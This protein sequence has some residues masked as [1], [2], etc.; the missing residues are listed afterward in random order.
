MRLFVRNINGEKVVLDISASTRKQLASKI[1]FKFYVKGEP[2]T[3][4]DVVAEPSSNDTA[5]GAVIGG[6]LGLLGGGVGVLIGGVAGGLI[7]GIRD[8]DEK[9]SINHFNN[10]IA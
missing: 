2:Y 9:K 1:G 10:S 3:V 5:G 6:L 8:E 7:G 4:D